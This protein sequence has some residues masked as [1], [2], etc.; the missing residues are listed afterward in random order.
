MAKRIRVGAW[1]QIGVRAVLAAGFVAFAL[2]GPRQPHVAAASACGPTVNP[3]ACENQNPGDP[4]SQWDVSGAGDA[5]IQGF[6]TDISVAPGGTEVFK[7]DTSASAY[8]IDI[9]RMGYYSGMGARKIATVTPSASLPQNQPNCLTNAASGLIDCAN[10][11]VSASW[12]VPTTAVSGIYF[13]K[14]TRNDTGGASHIFFVVRDDTGRSDILFQTSDTTWQAYNTYGGNSLYQGAP[15][16]SPSRAYKVSYNRPITTRGTGPEDFVF[17]AEYPM[18]R[19][20]ESNGYDVSYTTGVD[21]DR[22]GA[23]I[24]EH[25]IFVSNGH[26]EYWSGPQR[27]NVEAARA[28]GVNLAFFSGNE[29]FWKTRWETSIDGSN[30][31][32][33]TMVCYKETHA[34]RVLDPA[35]PPTWTGTW[36]DAR[37]SPPADGGRPENALTG[38]IFMVNDGDTGTMLVPAA[39]GK[40]RFWRN[41]SVAT[42]AAGATATLPSGVLGYEW[43]ADLDNGSRPAG[44]IRLSTTTR[45]VSGKLL[46]NG[47]TFGPGTVTHSLTLYRHPSGAL[48]F[49]AGTVQWAW[50]LDANHDRAGTAIDVRMK[51]ATVNLFAD[52]GVQPTTLQAGLVAASISAD[53]LSPTSTI[54]S[55]ANGANFTAGTAVTITGTATDAGGGIVSGVEVSVDNGATWRAATGTTSWSFSW[56]VSGSG[57]VTIRSRGYDDTGNMETPSPGVAINVSA[58]RTCPCSLWASTVVPPAPIDDGD[59]ASVELGMKFR[60]ETSGYITGVRFYKGSANVGNHIGNLWTSSGTLLA[61]AAFSGETAS[62]WQQVNFSSAVPVSANT[63]YVVSYFAPNGHYTGT[64]PYFTTALD[65]PPLH[66]L[67]DGVDGA[68]GIYVYSGS[69]AFPNQTFNSE[70]YWVDVVFN[71]TP[72]VDTTPPTITS[73]A[74]VAGVTTVDPAAPISATFSEA[75][76]PATISSSTAGKEG[77]AAP[78][79][80]ELRDNSGVMINSVVTYDSTTRVATLRPATSL[81]LGSTYVATMK[82]G[83]TD[84]RVKDVAGNAMAATVTWTFTTWATPPPPIVCPCS[85][86]PSTAVPTPVDDGDPN[87]VELGTKFRSDVAGFIMGARFYKGSLNTGTH[88]ARLWSSTGTQ[89]G[90]ATFANETASGWQEVAF[91]AP[92]AI[93][94]NTTYVISYHAPNGH[95]PGPDNYF[96]NAGIDTPPLHALRSGVDGANGIYAYGTTSVFPTNTFLGEGYFIDV[97][98]NTTTAPDTTPPF[99]STATPP[100]NA[101]GVRTNIT[102][103]ATF[104]EPMNSTTITTTSFVLRNPGGTTVP[105]TVSYDAGS[106]TATLTPSAALG[107]SVLYTAVVKAGV[108]DAAGNAT[109]S[110]YSWTFT[111]AAP[112]PPPPT[113]GPGGPVLVVTT[114]GNPFSTYYAEILRTEGF[115]AFATAD[116]SAVTSATLAGYDLVILGETS[117]TAAQVTMFTNWVTAGGNLIAMR[118]DK[119]LAGLLGLTDAA[120]TLA[121]AYLLVSAASGPGAGIVNQTVQFH[122]TADRYTLNGATSVAM[123]YSTATTATANPAVTLRQVGSGTAVAFTYDLARSIV[124]TREGNPAWSGQERDGQAPIRSDDLYFGAKAGDVQPDWIDFSKIAIPQADEQQRLLWNIILGSNANKKPLPRFWYFPRMLKAVV[125]MTGDDHANGGTAGRFDTYL[126]NSPVGCSVANWEC[127]RGTSYV[128]PNT[129]LTNTDAA[130]YVAQG[131]EVALHVNTNCGDWTPTSLASFYNTQLTQ[132]S[133]EYPNVPAPA[134]NRTHCIAWSDYATQPQLELNNGIRLDTTYYYWPSTW[135]QDRPGLFTGSG[136]P[137][138]FAT[139]TGQMIDVYQATTQITDESGQ[140]YTTTINALLDNA[141]GP[142]GYYGA[143]TANMHTDFNPS[144]G[145]TGSAAI[146]AS[147]KARGV[148]VI[149]AKQMLDWLDGRNAST[150]SSIA[151]NANVLTF[152][153]AVGAGATGLQ[154]L[155]PANVGPA[156]VNSVTLNGAPVTFTTQT[157]KGVAYAIFPAGAGAYAVTYGADTTPPTITNVV[158]T[159]SLNAAVVTW[160]TNELSDSK[161]NYGTNPAQ[162]ISVVS[163]ATPVTSHSLSIASLAP[164]TTYF[165]RVS[166]ADAASNTAVQPA[167]AAPA[168]SFTTAGATISGQIA[169]LTG[170]GGA[171]LTLNGAATGTAV[172]DGSGNYVF[173]GL[174][175]GSYTVAAS[176][177]GCTFSPAS[178]PVTIAGGSVT[179]MNFTAQAVTISGTISPAAIGS[180]ATV[181]LSGAASAVTTADASGNYSFSGM[182]DGA[183]TVTPSKSGFTFTPASSSVTV[184]RAN[185]TAVN[186]TGQAIPT[187]SVSGTISGGGGATVNLSGAATAST[188]ANASGNYSFTGLLNGSYTV[189]PVKSGFTFAPSSASVTIAGAN[190][191]A[192]FTAQAVVITGTISPVSIGSGATVTLSGAASAVVAADASGVYTFSGI[193]SG[194]YTVTPSKSGFTFTPANRAV[195]VTGSSV[196]AVDFTGQPVPTFSLSG[197]AAVGNATVNLTGSATAS[198]TA[199][200]AGNYSFSGLVNGSYTVTPVKGG[201]NFSPGSQAVT[202]ASANVTGVNFT[203]QAV[204]ITGTITPVSAGA[205]ATVTL[206]GAASAVVTADAGGN[207]AFIGIANG[208]YTVTPSK[209]GGV[210]FTPAS[211]SVT[212]SGTTVTGV[213]FAGSFTL[214]GTISGGGG[215]TVN[216]NGGATRTVTAD[217]S[218][219][220][221]FTGLLDGQYTITPVKSGFTMSPTSQVAVIQT[222]SVT[223]VNFVATPVPTFTISGTITPVS[224]GAGATMTLGGA[225]LT[226][227]A[228]A[229]GNYA[230]SGV[231]DGTYTVTPTKTGATFTP[232]NQSVTVSGANVSGV[233]FTG[234]ITV[235]PIAVD[236]TVTRGQSTRSTAITSPA[237]S[238]TAPNELLLAFISGD[239]VDATSATRVTGITTTGL[240]WTFVGRTNTQRGT[241]EIWRAFAANPVTSVT[242][243]ATLSQGVA[244]AITVMSFKNVDTTGTNGSGAI[245]ATGS[246]NSLSGAPTA[247]LTTTRANSLVIGV[248]SDWDQAINRT[249]GPNQSIV[250][251]FLATDGD[252]FWVQRQNGLIAASGTVVTIN[253]TAPTTDRFNLTICEVLGALQ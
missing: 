68:N 12:P 218:G 9:Y 242:A 126:A 137:M 138:R 54:T 189:T 252:T 124:Q 135:V 17:N 151:W 177:N 183:Y 121:D 85:I 245:G 44:L 222:A 2:S 169:P 42:L 95:Y 77:S 210:A 118:P 89:L 141:L 75:M 101:S 234:V 146:V 30:T 93:A 226:T 73:T 91:P 123:L 162:L 61:S 3:I 70:N 8:S 199:D 94:A 21:T 240:T 176:K 37:F 194:S 6:A 132:F 57:T 80:F 220:Y 78:G 1:R 229:S 15:G 236:A 211:R 165:Y 178:Q 179:G 205:G 27:A 45:N 122:G 241:A 225:G 154:A 143:I 84:P 173:S 213:D 116:L 50:G 76:D 188:T 223:G 105:A 103:T 209:S 31:S 36:R 129:P 200:T 170:C 217:A 243:R 153:V 187:F 219:N 159:P 150:F 227:T 191:T 172:A 190:A 238:T 231:P 69:S 88:T 131:F 38:T 7:I 104:N 11:A 117:L 46:D 82:G 109:A 195:T 28:A 184:A 207:Y 232:A 186:F 52:M 136:M 130:N 239:N 67:R 147:A 251:Q 20:L 4:S 125:I 48:V 224:A 23:E 175:N 49:G 81:Q 128:Y 149:S 102:V 99:V 5:S 63:T 167:P 87:S 110:D 216:M 106:R 60:T 111:T 13:A 66:G 120:S 161:V 108:K 26:D 201:Y 58:T 204:L 237:F 203:A 214:S 215:A 107:N 180:G 148:P 16:T 47:S 235:A 127:I 145:A 185:V 244:A 114:T 19:W 119:Q 92:I 163:N 97:V 56:V 51:Q 18:V 164:N 86:W 181:T 198:T 134:T 133:G 55:P 35:D 171:T 33:R 112:P 64:D 144:E 139:A 208:S 182:V 71:T 158:A 166:S 174:S 247:S 168:S 22:R 24:L 40:A 62:G 249:V 157:I 83:S 29:V 233:N 202:I 43:D 115:N 32:Y 10:W 41:T 253:D 90:V 74:P 72:P 34:G 25:T 193:A 152:T 39:D 155:V 96:T 212:V 79:T 228:D 140:T 221:S 250:S 100:A 65:N 230:F 59:S 246:N 248:G 98:F 196:T 53:A 142:L 14:L 113:Q 197:T 206:S 156:P 160:T 192:N